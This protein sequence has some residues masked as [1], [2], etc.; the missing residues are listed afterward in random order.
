VNLGAVLADDSGQGLGEYGLILGLVAVVCV[1]V[2]VLVG[3]NLA[4]ILTKVG[5]VL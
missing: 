4:K 3:S 2:L 5:T 1:A